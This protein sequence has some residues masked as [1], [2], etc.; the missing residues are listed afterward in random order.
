MLPACGRRA[1]VFVWLVRVCETEIA[2]MGKNNGKSRSGV[3]EKNQTGLESL[4]SRITVL[5]S[6]V[7]FACLPH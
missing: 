4:K 5:L 3:R 2:H 7:H 6:F 1:A